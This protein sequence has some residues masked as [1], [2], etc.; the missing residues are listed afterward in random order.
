MCKA[1]CPYFRF[2]PSSLSTY[3]GAS[4]TRSA[5]NTYVQRVTF[6]KI[7]EY[8][9]LP[10]VYCCLRFGL[11]FIFKPQFLSMVHS[12]PSMLRYVGRMLQQLNF[13]SPFKFFGPLSDASKFTSPF[14]I[15]KLKQD[16]SCK[17]FITWC[18]YN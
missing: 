16:G 17:H 6:K 11:W 3:V 4:I 12:G 2:I 7:W 14:M 10:H 15:C 1:V 8:I 9:N 5:L 13:Q 18:F